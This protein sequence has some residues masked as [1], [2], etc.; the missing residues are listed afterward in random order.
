MDVSKTFDCAFVEEQDV[1]S[2]YVGR[3]LSPEEAEA[4]EEHYFSCER[5]WAE[6][7]AATE[8]R[9]ALEE[10]ATGLPETS[11]LAPQ[12]SRVIQGPWRTWA[13][14]AAAAA[15][16]FAIGAGFLISRR[17]SRSADPGTLV[18]GLA[19]AVGQGHSI[20]ARLTGGFK[21]PAVSRSAAE[22]NKAPS[23]KVFAEA[24]KIKVAAGEKP[25]PEMA[26]TLALAH[27]VT[28]DIDNAVERLREATLRAP[29]DP[30]PHSDLAA[31]YLT[32]ADRKGRSDAVPL[33]LS[34][35][36]IAIRLRP[37]LPEAHFNR[38]LA[39]E[40]MSLK[41]QA[42]A[43]W[44][45]YLRLDP[46]SDWASEAR[47]RLKTPV[48]ARPPHRWD[49]ARR[50]L[51]HWVE[52][53]A[54]P[55]Q[56]RELISRFPQQVRECFEAELLPSWTEQI[57]IRPHQ[58]SMHRLINLETIANEHCL[59]TGD[60]LLCDAIAAAERVFSSGDPVQL[61]HLAEG[62]KQFR[63]GRS[64]IDR[65]E[66][67][68]ARPHFETSA[69]EL[70]LA[71]N[72]VAEWADF[73]R[74]MCLYY[75]DRFEE[76][77]EVC[78]RLH[79]LAERRSYT[80]LL[81]RS[82]WMQG[83]VRL[84]TGD[85]R[86]SVADYTTALAQFERNRESGYASALHSLLAGAF[87]YL[88]ETKQ[89]WNHRLAALR[90]LDGLDD[91]R[92]AHRV[93]SDAAVAAVS[94][95]LPLVGLV[96]Q[97]AAVRTAD[98]W[99]SSLVSME[100]YLYRSF[101]LRRLGRSAEAAAD[102]GKARRWLTK[103]DDPELKRGEA[104]ELSAAL[105]ELD[106]TRRPV[107]AQRQL[108]SA[109]DYFRAT[110]QP[111]RLADVYLLRARAYANGGDLTRAESDLA[112]GIEELERQRSLQGTFAVSFFEKSWKFFD[113]IAS[114]E[115]RRGQRPEL[116]L[117]YAERLR[118]RDLL[119][120]QSAGDRARSSSAPLESRPLSPDQIRLKLPPSTA[121][122]YF[123]AL[124]DRLLSW[125]L[126]REAVRFSQQEIRADE[127]ARRVTLYRM[128]LER[129][130]P[131]SETDRWGA[132]L[133]DTLIRPYATFLSRG[134]D[135]VVIPDGPLYEVPFAS[136]LDRKTGR[137]LVQDFFLT[138][139]PSG[140]AF[141]A[142]SDRLRSLTPGDQLQVTVFGAPAL[143]Q[144]TASAL[145]AL[146]HAAEEARSIAALYPR[147]RH[148]SVRKLLP[149][150][151]WRPRDRVGFFISPVTLFPIRSTR[152]C[153]G[154]FWPQAATGRA[155]ISSPVRSMAAGF[156]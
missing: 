95:D 148:F 51:L 47:Q 87:S 67:Q 66:A 122:L 44:T 114:L 140:T 116:V 58:D 10:K 12:S 14:L 48:G 7:Q 103:I 109:L 128:T 56:I 90:S 123:A 146:P 115:T 18:A 136:L 35:A 147:G 94:A 149:R 141:L 45:E 74:A 96:L 85:V 98:A 32:L 125:L 37:S 108:T 120:R 63:L 99:K 155:E 93:F 104:A 102:L 78:G 31:A 73:Y 97:D 68:K 142:A 84:L 106:V 70:R 27:L 134:V 25:S 53:G 24:E 144:N 8:L 145:P 55:D 22:P 62:L 80:A 124:Q 43:E 29:D 60:Q 81:G 79:A 133:Y 83:L 72:P 121:L 57:E 129:D 21:Y 30:L 19:E 88:A 156:P 9:A 61:G 154:S 130:A 82:L 143:D 33:A 49:P 1:V 113:E 111:M 59:I 132:D 4:F 71:G 77:A 40:K 119:A 28:G 39:L 54:K 137:Y 13:P 105:G 110:S 112:T 26:R 41:D 151:F 50:T 42:K 76:S 138:A 126:T 91:P 131:I 20:R 3:K 6:V 15:I 101:V 150:D 100:A 92:R 69:A 23:W 86:Q 118:A 17:P 52:N 46:D 135:L 153:L 5:C 34:E 64:L 36:E 2:R 65:I 117:A 75:A 139:S 107:E 127:L 11:G 38:A 16:A 89:S 152:I